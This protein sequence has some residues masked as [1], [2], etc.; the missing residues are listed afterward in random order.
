[1]TVTRLL[2]RQILPVDRDTDVFPLYVDLEEARLDAD[3][4]DVGGSRAA[5]D[6][7]AAI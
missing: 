7:K 4:Y 3:R 2:Q 5:K 6:L 1:M